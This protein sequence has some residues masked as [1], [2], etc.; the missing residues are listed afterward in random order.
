MLYLGITTY[1]HSHISIRICP[2][3]DG[4]NP[5]WLDLDSDLDFPRL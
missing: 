2:E 1:P 4:E 3:V 5:L